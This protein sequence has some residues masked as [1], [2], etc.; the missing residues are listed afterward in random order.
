VPSRSFHPSTQKTSGPQQ[1]TT[2]RI[3]ERTLSEPSLGRDLTYI[4]VP[5]TRERPALC[6]GALFAPPRADGVVLIFSSFLSSSQANLTFPQLRLCQTDEN[7]LISSWPVTRTL[8]PLSSLQ[9]RHAMHRPICGSQKRLMG[10]AHTTPHSS[11]D[12]LSLSSFLIAV[13]PDWDLRPP[14]P[15]MRLTARVTH[16]R[17]EGPHTVIARWG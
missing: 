9:I 13:S 11:L 17:L 7:T 10:A 15:K 2:S 3:D 5:S 1:H 14:P 4:H 12:R 16:I 6:L 8:S